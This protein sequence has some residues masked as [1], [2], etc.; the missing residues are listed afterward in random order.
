MHRWTINE[1]AVQAINQEKSRSEAEAAALVESSD[2]LP[3]FRTWAK[4]EGTSQV[5]LTPKP[6]L[7]LSQLISVA[8]YVGPRLTGRRNA[9][10]GLRMG[11]LGM[12]AQANVNFCCHVAP[13]PGGV[14]KHRWRKILPITR[15]TGSIPDHLLYEDRRVVYINMYRKIYTVVN[16]LLVGQESNRRNTG[17]KGS[18]KRH[19]GAPMGVGTKRENLCITGWQPPESIHLGRGPTQPRRRWWCQ[20]VSRQPSGF[21]HSPATSDRE[22]PYGS[23]S[24]SSHT[25]GWSV[26]ATLNFQTASNIHQCW[27]PDTL[28][29]EGTSPGRN[30]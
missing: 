13:L 19:V 1:S 28:F 11:W 26:S 14:E 5:A 3:R 24:I 16:G 4:P 2:P 30:K 7:P 27:A 12:W 20:P 18:G 29:L 10:L 25:E 22:A 23:E 17:G 15:S 6:S 8:A 9:K 21:W